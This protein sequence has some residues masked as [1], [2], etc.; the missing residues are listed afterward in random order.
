[1]FA[2]IKQKH[3]DLWPPEGKFVTA[4]IIVKLDLRDNLDVIKNLIAAHV[5][6]TQWINSNKD[7]AIKEFN[8]QLRK[9]TGKE[10]PKDALAESLTRLEFTDD[11]IKES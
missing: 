10:L 11:P 8:V 4:H 7:Q 2:L 6:E 3:Q 1:M 9:L 5:N